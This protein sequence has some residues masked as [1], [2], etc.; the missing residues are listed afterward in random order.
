MC[1][2]SGWTECVCLVYIKSNPEN[3]LKFQPKFPQELCDVCV[4]VLFIAAYHYLIPI[5]KH[6][7]HCEKIRERESEREDL[8]SS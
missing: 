4:R 5:Y 8:A 2:L 1:T 6:Y 3:K 7:I